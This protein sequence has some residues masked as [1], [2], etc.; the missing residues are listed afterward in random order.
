M[1][2]IKVV[3]DS[4]RII[5]STNVSSEKID[6]DSY[7][8]R[9]TYKKRNYILHI[10]RKYKLM[11]LE[12]TESIYGMNINVDTLELINYIKEMIIFTAFEGYN[13]F[14]LSIRKWY[15]DIYIHKALQA[16]VDAGCGDLIID[17]E[18]MDFDENA[19]SNSE[20]I[21]YNFGLNSFDE[22]LFDNDWQEDFNDKVIVLSEEDLYIMESTLVSYFYKLLNNK[23]E[24]KKVDPFIISYL[25]SVLYREIKRRLGDKSFEIWFNE[26]QQYFDEENLEKYLIERSKGKTKKLNWS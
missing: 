21:L 25:T 6:E 8:L 14:S 17:S 16:T 1:K 20:I 10:N 26:W 13:I 15:E 22:R 5:N 18:F 12:T 9:F 24:D 11:M 3:K 4:L 19:G 23:W 2:D 7:D